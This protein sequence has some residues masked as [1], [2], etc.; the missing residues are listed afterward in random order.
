[1]EIALDV[2]ELI[3]YFDAPTLK[4]GLKY[5]K[6][7]RVEYADLAAD[8]MII[9][10]VRGSRLYYSSL[11]LDEDEHDILYTQ[12]SCPLA[13][14]CKH[15]VALL[16]AFL[17]HNRDSFST[18]AR[19][20]ELAESLLPALTIFP[21]NGKTVST[22]LPPA[23][24][25]CALPCDS[26]ETRQKLSSLLPAP[27]VR[28]SFQLI[29]ELRQRVDQ[30][31]D[32]FIGSKGHGRYQP[33]NRIIYLLKDG[34]ENLR[35]EVA[36]SSV[37][38]D[39]SLGAV[40]GMHVD[41]LTGSSPPSYAT[42]EDV[43]IARLW[44]KIN[45]HTWRADRFEDCVPEAVS[46]L[47]QRILATGRCYLNSAAELLLRP[48]RTLPAVLTWVKTAGGSY[49]LHLVAQAGTEEFPCL[50]WQQPWYI[51]RAT[52]ECGP[53]LCDFPADLL[54]AFR[55]MRTLTG[56]EARGLPLLLAELELTDLVP[57]SP[58]EDAVQ[59]NLVAPIP[60]LTIQLLSPEGAAKT[61]RVPVGLLT[62]QR[63]EDKVTSGESGELMVHKYDRMGE[64]KCKQRLLDFGLQEREGKFFGKP[65][66]ESCFH[67]NA[68]ERWLDF[69][70]ELVQLRSEGWQISQKSESLLDPID[71][72]ADDLS[73]E[74]SDDNSWWFS[75]A[76][77][78][79]INGKQ[80]PLLP[81][82]VAAV[83][84]LP[85]G[86]KIVNSV[87][88]LNQ[89]GKFHAYLDDGRLVRLPF[90][91]VRSIIVSLGEL[92]QKTENSNKLKASAMDLKNLYDET[93]FHSK[94]TG[95]DRMQDLFERL[96]RLSQPLEIS[97][98][99]MLKAELRPYQ[100]EGVKWLQQLS[101]EKFGGLLADDMGLGKT[102]QL[103]AHI[104][105]EKENGR[106]NT[107]FLV[108]CPTSVLPN[109]LSEV[110]KFT[111]GLKVL[112]FYG[113][114]RWAKLD[115]FDNYDLVVT[116]YS[117]I[118][119]DSEKMQ[120]LHWH[121]VAIDE[122]Q[123]IKNANTDVARA[124]RVLR[125]NHRFCL[126]GTPVENNLGELWSHFQF[127][128]PGLLGDQKTFNTAIRNPIEKEGDF[129]R[130]TI[131]T[132]RIRPFLIRRTKQQVATEL[133]EKT[134][135]IQ[136]I[137]LEGAQRDL[138]ETVRLASTEQVRDEIA[139]KGFKQSQIIILDALLKLRQVCC[140][141]RLVKLT[142]ASKVHTSAKLDLLMEM[143]TQLID[144]GRK[145]L[146]FSQFTSMLDLVSDE[147]RQ[148]N[149]KYVELRGDTRQRSI[150]V[151]QFQNGDYPVFLLSL[152]A[153][154]TG[155]NL[156][157]ADV[158]IHYDPWWNPAV[159]DQ[160]TDRA[161]RIGQDK[162]VFVYKLIAR[163]TIE[164]RM[165]ELQERK[166]SLAAGIY[167]ENGGL[168]AALTENDLMTLL[169]PIDEY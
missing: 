19:A 109:W 160:A 29:A 158:V 166:R 131:L 17:S 148:K 95:A 157:A 43:E 52:G 93:L 151:K 48:G 55:K 81:L 8:S 16:L 90:D 168:S 14:D 27:E 152:K 136:Q 75:L 15:T 108:V 124:V 31:S 44:R 146:L 73:F 162:Q 46:A 83:R 34:S 99:E 94:W 82:L 150:P 32:D 133:P 61:Q 107:P 5:F 154:G 129:S 105:L 87:D 103:L 50:T 79:I 119:R 20:A 165:L 88:Q 78:I 60:E 86:D 49:G 6:E 4:K 42:T 80:V 137:E 139:K 143:L 37:R 89:D 91:R 67:F 123:A 134:I 74:I 112:A 58:C 1:M 116:T 69:R 10:S 54:S 101:R 45:G 41:N 130:K 159:E 149:I 38:K 161:H 167:D 23:T 141:P 24:M 18:P 68:P 65:A 77:N 76:L 11:T 140:D 110:E 56:A 53:A 2:Q 147:L 122:A 84:Q 127:A 57:P 169:S 128:L 21:A 115:K 111:P 25:Q 62:F 114:D 125:A 98:P 164:Q 132:A 63:H 71:L 70:A 35:I 145:I 26:E 113:S 66:A 144:D 36:S 13:G 100:M 138:Y 118:S 22:S 92:L 155:L 64:V 106:M 12:C 72:T 28:R 59:L 85:A 3:E 102:V 33:R 51:N 30:S 117:L 39:N 153:G 156:T 120:K 40:T 97:V 163:G 47:I 135:T 96:R 9:G 121:G 142:A 104:C 126:T 7:K